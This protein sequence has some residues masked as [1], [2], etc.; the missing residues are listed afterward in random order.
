MF[1]DKQSFVNALL[2][3]P[4]DPKT[5]VYATRRRNF[6]ERMRKQGLEEI[7]IDTVKRAYWL[8]AAIRFDELQRIHLNTPRYMGR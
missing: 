3:D 7:S 8:S 5:G 1:K 2:G 6:I 4:A